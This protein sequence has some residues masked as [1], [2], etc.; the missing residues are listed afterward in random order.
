MLETLALS[1][2]FSH[3]L[4]FSVFS[5]CHTLFCFWIPFNDTYWVDESQTQIV[6]LVQK[7]KNKLLSSQRVPPPLS[8]LMRMLR[9]TRDAGDRKSDSALWSYTRWLETTFPSATLTSPPA[10]PWLHKQMNTNLV[11][12]THIHTHRFPPYLKHTCSQ[13]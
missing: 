10:T 4:S 7:E 2:A 11:F 8:L 13:G 1:F 5:L 9:L 6:L 12:L 3:S